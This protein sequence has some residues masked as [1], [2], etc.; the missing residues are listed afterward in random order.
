MVVSVDAGHWTLYDGGV[1]RWRFRAHQGLNEQ[2]GAGGRNLRKVGMLLCQ[3]RVSE[4]N[5]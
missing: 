5:L 2:D 4:R 1:A 3:F